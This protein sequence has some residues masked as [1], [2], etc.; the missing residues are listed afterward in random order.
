MGNFNSNFPIEVVGYLSN[1]PWCNDFSLEY[2]PEKTKFIFDNFK[3]E[4]SQDRTVESIKFWE[5]LDEILLNEAKTYKGVQFYEKHKFNLKFLQDVITSFFWKYRP[6]HTDSEAFELSWQKYTEFTD[7]MRDKSA[8]N[9]ALRFTKFK[10][11]T[12]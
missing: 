4:P 10:E 3:T 5:K 1:K 11:K 9:L 2:D 12:I 8:G 7:V 6:E